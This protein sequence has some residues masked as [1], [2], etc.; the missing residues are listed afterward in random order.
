MK[1]AIYQIPL[2]S[3][4][5]IRKELLLFDKIHI[6]KVLIEQK[7]SAYEN[8]SFFDKLDK[9]YTDLDYLV[10]QNQVEILD[11]EKSVQ[12]GFKYLMNQSNLEKISRDLSDTEKEL[13]EK[14]MYYLIEKANFNENFLSIR[15]KLRNEINSNLSGK[16]IAK[17]LLT[18]M[19]LRE[20]YDSSCVEI[21]SILMNTRSMDKNITPVLSS[22]QF[23]NEPNKKSLKQFKSIKKSER[24]SVINTTKKVDV[25]NVVLG[26]LPIPSK[27]AALQDILEFKS[28]KENLRK[29]RDLNRWINKVSTS[30]TPQREIEDEIDYLLNEYERIL[31]LNKLKFNYSKTEIILNITLGTLEKLIKIQW[32]KL[33]EGFIEFKKAKA[34]FKLAESQATGREL[35][36][37]FEIS[38]KLK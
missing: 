36:Y 23:F 20:K 14:K 11:I 27:Q 22:E 18:Y 37:L 15:P 31:K 7:K 30:N 16:E 5:D 3:E 19:S 4:F 2:V 35:A 26:K 24:N 25:V 1:E 28:D 33:G 6:P 38:D 13:L 17:K 10:N 29:I 32:S 8:N 34:D 9:M 21:A 12:K